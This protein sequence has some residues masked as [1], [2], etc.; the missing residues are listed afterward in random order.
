MGKPNRG[1]QMAHDTKYVFLE[2]GCTFEN[3]LYDWPRF[4]DDSP[5]CPKH[6]TRVDYKMRLCSRKYTDKCKG[7]HKVSK[8]A[9][10]PIIVCPVCRPE[11][12]R[13]NSAETFARVLRK[14][15]AVGTGKKYQGI[16]CKAYDPFP[17][18][19]LLK[20]KTI[21]D[22]PELGKIIQKKC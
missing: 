17:K 22:F 9:N 19:K 20:I 5:H 7:W 3:P 18:Q 15:E 10:Q 4:R 11:S 6:G 13:R 8:K 16:E 12:Y 21:D 14:R 1:A 2:C